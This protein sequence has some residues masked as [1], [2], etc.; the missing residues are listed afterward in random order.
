MLRETLKEYEKAEELRAQQEADQAN[1]PFVDAIKLWYADKTGDFEHPID[2]VTKQG[3][4]PCS[5]RSP[6]SISRT[7]STRKQRM[8]D[9]MGKA[10]WLP[11][12]CG[13]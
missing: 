3:Y 1:I 9:W 10:V 8:V 7:I 5:A 4:E 13:F 2:E 12:S 6:N 11:E